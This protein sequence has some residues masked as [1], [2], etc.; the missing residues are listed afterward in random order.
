MYKNLL[1]LIKILKALNLY[2]N[3]IFQKYWLF[4]WQFFRSQILKIINANNG[5]NI[6]TEIIAY[7]SMSSQSA[8][9]KYSQIF[10][11]IS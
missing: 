2:Q 10:F 11:A 7:N 8:Y 4:C 3:I 5:K 1:Y 6:I 9:S